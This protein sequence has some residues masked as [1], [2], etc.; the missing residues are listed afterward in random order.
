MKKVDNRTYSVYMHTTSDGRVY[1]GMT[2]Q[3]PEDRWSRGE[4]YKDHP[5]FYQAIKEEGWDN[6][7]HEVLEVG[8]SRAEAAELEKGLIAE[9]NSTDLLGLIA[10]IIS[11]YPFSSTLIL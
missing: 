10:T 1:I 3:R 4:G 9:Y 7:E 5:R 6:I 2:G 11:L 8:L